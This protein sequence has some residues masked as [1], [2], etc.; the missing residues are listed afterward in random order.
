MS[1]GVSSF[2]GLIAWQKARELNRD[3]Y[4][5]SNAGDFA[6]YFGL[7]DQICRASVSISSNIARPVE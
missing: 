1:M 6:K 7:R 5:V 3:I 2:E 4:R